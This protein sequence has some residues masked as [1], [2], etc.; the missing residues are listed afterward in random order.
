M[1][2]PRPQNKEGAELDLLV[3]GRGRDSGPPSQ[4][5]P[6]PVALWGSPRLCSV[7]TNP[8]R[9]PLAQKPP[10]IGSAQRP[11]GQNPGVSEGAGGLLGRS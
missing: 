10:G 6:L 9:A 3:G 5:W 11:L 2:C 7:I 4:W 8:G 1:T